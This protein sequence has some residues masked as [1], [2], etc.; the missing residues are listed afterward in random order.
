VLF[1]SSSGKSG[2]SL[3]TVFRSQ[4]PLLLFLEFLSLNF[5]F[6]SCFTVQLSW[7]C[8]CRFLCDSLFTIIH[9]FS[10]VNT[11]LKIFFVD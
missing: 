4:L 10:F 5:F 3:F 1:D 6:Q 8:F 7:F 9:I 2:L 11:F